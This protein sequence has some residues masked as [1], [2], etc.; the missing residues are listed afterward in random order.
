MVYVGVDDCSTNSMLG[1]KGFECFERAKRLKQKCL[2]GQFGFGGW[3]RYVSNAISSR[4]SKCFN[5]SSVAS[6]SSV[7]SALGASSASIAS[8]VSSWTETLETEWSHRTCCFTCSNVLQ[9]SQLSFKC[10]ILLRVCQLCTCLR[11]FELGVRIPAGLRPQMKAREALETELTASAF[12]APPC[13]AP[14]GMV[15]PRF[16]FLHPEAQRA[17][18]AVVLKKV[19]L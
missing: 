15:S 17:S 10:F 16:F 4:F 7:S 8:S 6:A 2:F 11:V 3:S 14:N 1:F 9:M 12:C 13:Q 19:W 18:W 5:I